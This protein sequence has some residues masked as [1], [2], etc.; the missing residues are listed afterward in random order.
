VPGIGRAK[1]DKYGDTIVSL[2]ASESAPLSG[3]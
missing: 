3:S 1:I 2:C